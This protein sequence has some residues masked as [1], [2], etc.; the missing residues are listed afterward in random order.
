MGSG[1]FRLGGA[2]PVWS[3]IPVGAVCRVSPLLGAESDLST[4]N[5]P[6]QEADHSLF[7]MFGGFLLFV[8]FPHEAA[9]THILKTALQ[10]IYIIA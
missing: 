1:Y 5:G 8:F 6:D 10:Q 2:Q 3:S 9:I 4:S 7:A